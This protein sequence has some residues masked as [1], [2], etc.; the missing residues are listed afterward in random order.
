MH[1]RLHLWCALACQTSSCW[2][3]NC[4]KLQILPNSVFWGILCPYPWPIA[5]RCNYA[6]VNLWCAKLRTLWTQET[7]DPGHFGTGLLGPN[8]PDRS[9][10]VPKCRQDSL[11]LSAELSCPQ[12]PN[13]PVSSAEVSWPISDD[14]G[15]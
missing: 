13:C 2:A 6:R 5:A 15:M 1:T 3:K 14:Y 10:L 11:D 9:A 7:S 4:Q 12:V 8:C